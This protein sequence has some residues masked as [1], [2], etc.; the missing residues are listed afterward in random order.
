MNITIITIGKIKETYLKHGIEEYKKRLKGH[1]KCS[2]VELADEKTPEMASTKEKEQIKQKE[3]GRILAKIPAGS[4]VIALEPGGKMLSSEE[5]A[6]KISELALH[7]KSRITF[8]IGGSLGLDQRIL[9]ESNLLW[10]FSRLTFPHQLIRLVL[11]EQVYR[12]FQI[13]AGSPYHK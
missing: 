8:I 10:S 11:M 1:A 7:G 3:G 9:N 5:L 6:S 4:Y 12:A 13:N 2:I